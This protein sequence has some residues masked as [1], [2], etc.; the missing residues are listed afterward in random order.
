ME[1]LTCEEVRPCLTKYWIKYITVNPNRTVSLSKFS[2]F[3]L[4]NT[5]IFVSRPSLRR[6]GPAALV[7]ST[8]E[9]R[10]SSVLHFLSDDAIFI[11]KVRRNAFQRCNRL[12]QQYFKFKERYTVQFNADDRSIVQ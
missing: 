3:K 2:F 4:Q 11:R 1:F 9:D 7:T 12:L 10:I 8:Q 6:M 5:A